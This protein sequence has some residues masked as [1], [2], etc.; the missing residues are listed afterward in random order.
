MKIL[1]S[2]IAIYFL[3]LAIWLMLISGCLDYEAM[4]NQRCAGDDSLTRA[5]RVIYKPLIQ[6]IL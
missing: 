4:H 5:V 2:I 6:I 3:P 1:T